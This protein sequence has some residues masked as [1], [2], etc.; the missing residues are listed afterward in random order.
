MSISP[1][2]RRAIRWVLVVLW[3]GVIFYLSAQSD[4]PHYPEAAL[5]V[6]IKKVGHMA[7]Y[8]I[9]AAL[10]WWACRGD[11]VARPTRAFLCAFLVAA[12]YAVSDEGHQYFVPGRNPQPLDV[13]FDVAGA[14]LSLLLIRRTL[15]VREG[16]PAR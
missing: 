4:L 11:Q 9:L 15:R 13:G 3:M 12:L 6:V 10:A 2:G 7:E 14:T 1:T 8:G 16:R 5:D